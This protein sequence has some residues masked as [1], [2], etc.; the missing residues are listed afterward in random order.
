VS[1]FVVVERREPEDSPFLHLSRALP[2]TALDAFLRSPRPGEPQV[3]RAVCQASGGR[4]ADRA[5]LID[6]LRAADPALL[7]MAA[8]AGVVR[9]SLHLPVAGLL[10]TAQALVA[11]S[12]QHALPAVWTRVEEGV[13]LHRILVPPGQD[14]H[15]LAE[16]LRGFLEAH[17]AEAEVAVEAASSAAVVVQMERIAEALSRLRPPSPGGPAE[18]P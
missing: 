4:A 18:G 13:L 2:G 10:P 14:P 16:R 9:V 1:Y 17:G 8:P 7:P 6:A 11:F 12:A 15:A 3:V 5:R